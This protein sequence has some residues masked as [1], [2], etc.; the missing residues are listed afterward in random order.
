MA[1][2]STITRIRTA[3]DAADLFAPLL[4]DAREERLIV[5]HL[6]AEGELLRLSEAGR[7]SEDAVPL[8]MRRIVREALFVEAAAIILAH[9]HPSGDPSPSN[10]D[11]VTTRRLAE[12][13]RA[14]GVGLRDHLIFASR[15]CR[16]LRA[17]GLL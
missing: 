3:R 15:E 6:G 11:M 14:L 1:S 7:G 8:P 16:S 10:R 13:A 12:I 17:M 5:A 2:G 9:N 4:A